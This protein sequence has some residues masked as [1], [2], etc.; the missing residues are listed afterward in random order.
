MT[1]LSHHLLHKVLFA[2][3][4]EVTRFLDLLFVQE[5]QRPKS[6][7][8]LGRV[9]EQTAADPVILQI[10]PSHRGV[11]SHPHTSCSIT[12][13]NTTENRHQV[14]G[15]NPFISGRVGNNSKLKISQAL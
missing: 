12:G 7:V 2:S 8:K 11:L 10:N 13:I 3:L 15:I 14:T 6:Q 5:H 1:S 4:Q 9:L